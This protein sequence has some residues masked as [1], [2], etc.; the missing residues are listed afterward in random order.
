MPPSCSG[1]TGN[2]DMTMDEVRQIP[3]WCPLPEANDGDKVTSDSD[4]L[5]TA[6]KVGHFVMKLKLKEENEQ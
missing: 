2:R 5:F 4:E 3:D 6:V 1:I